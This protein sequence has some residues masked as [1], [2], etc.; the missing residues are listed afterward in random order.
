LARTDSENT[1]PDEIKRTTGPQT[2]NGRRWEVQLSATPSSEWLQL[3]RGSGEAS[4]RALP[5]RVE[6]DTTA[7]YFKSE[8][9][10]V[11]ALDRLD[12]QVDRVDERAISDDSRPGPAGAARPLRCRDKGK[13]TG[14]LGPIASLPARAYGSGRECF[15]GDVPIIAIVDDDASVRRSLLRVVESAGYKAETFGSAREFLAWLPHGRAAC[16]VL[17]VHMDELSGFDL[18]DR[19]TVPIVFTT[20]H[21]DPLTVARIERS[22]AGHLR[23]PFDRAAV[24]DMI[25]RIVEP[26]Q[27]P[28]SPGSPTAVERPP[29]GADER[30]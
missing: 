14:H 3:F 18:Y 13:G 25:R 9:D 4:A 11:G 7:A 28:G 21:D 20:G 27:S 12:R 15:M 6:F 23:K 10:Q 2:A 24:L 1:R 16:L 22:T 26:V 29:R 17:D 30:S 5:Q 8:E 19:L